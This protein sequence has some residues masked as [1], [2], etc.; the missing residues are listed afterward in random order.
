MTTE[1]QESDWEESGRKYRERTARFH[2]QTVLEAWE[3]P[4][5]VPASQIRKLME[6]RRLG[7]PDDPYTGEAGSNESRA[8]SERIAKKLTAQEQE[9]A[10]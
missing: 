10:R 2:N 4:D 9:R 1:Y 3:D 5:C 6:R 7:E 8:R